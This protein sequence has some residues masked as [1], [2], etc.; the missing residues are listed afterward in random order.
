M[1]KVF[2]CIAKI[3]KYLRKNN[4]LVYF[5]ERKLFLKTAVAGIIHII[6]I[7]LER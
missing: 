5:V 3:T 7:F 4:L 1:R 2:F 6:N